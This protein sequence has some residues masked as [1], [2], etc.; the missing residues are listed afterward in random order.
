MISE[1]KSGG[2]GKLINFPLL[3]EELQADIEF[4]VLDSVLFDVVT[5]R[6]TLKRLDG[7]LDF[8]AGQIWLDY[9]S[10]KAVL[11]IFSE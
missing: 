10:Q 1:D 8:K 3:L 2:K 5:G 6:S 7:V 9:R 4:I 11:P